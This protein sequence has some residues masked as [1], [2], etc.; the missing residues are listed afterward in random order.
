MM[1][2]MKQ[3]DWQF[4]EVLVQRG[5]PADKVIDWDVEVTVRRM[6]KTPMAWPGG[7]T[8]EAVVPN[9]P[10]DQEVAQRFETKATVEI[11]GTFP[12]ARLVATSDGSPRS[13]IKFDDIGTWVFTEK[14]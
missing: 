4:R 1:D 3:M 13:V 10:E 7:G 12:G 8:Y 14:K 11:L 5:I 6:W 2:N 9:G